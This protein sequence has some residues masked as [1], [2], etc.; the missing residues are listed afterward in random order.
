MISNHPKAVKEQLLIDCV[1]S[2]I[3]FL[4]HY[5]AANDY[6]D[7]VQKHY[8]TIIDLNI[9]LG[10]EE[11]NKL[12]AKKYD[13]EVW[14]LPSALYYANVCHER[15][16]GTAYGNWENHHAKKL[17][18]NC[19]NPESKK[20]I[21]KGINYKEHIVDSWQSWCITHSIPVDI[22][23]RVAKYGVYI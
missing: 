10:W 3:E 18:S 13:S 15:L 2:H 23:D 5:I 6:E 21:K 20:N 7:E 4:I 11:A 12:V 22:F 16:T 8:Q 1:E 19:C 17:H 9:D 14:W